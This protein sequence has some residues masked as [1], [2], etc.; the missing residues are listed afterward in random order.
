M[1]RVCKFP[2]G[3][4]AY[5]VASDARTNLKAFSLCCVI[6]IKVKRVKGIAVSFIDSVPF[7]FYNCCTTV[8]VF[9]LSEPKI[10]HMSYVEFVFKVLS[11]VSVLPHEA[12][13]VL[14]AGLILPLAEHNI[15]LEI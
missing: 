14:T 4:V 13:T 3:R 1:I 11:E 6:L 2:S 7:P 10:E 12:N 8:I 9:C 5:K 15:I